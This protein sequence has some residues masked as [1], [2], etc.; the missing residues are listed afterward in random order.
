[1]GG[2]KDLDAVNQNGVILEKQ[3]VLKKKIILFGQTSLP[4]INASILIKEQYL[5]SD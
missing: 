3:K 5:R 1:M 4:H 2:K